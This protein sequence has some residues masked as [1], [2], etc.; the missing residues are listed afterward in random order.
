MSVDL[1]LVP[2]SEF[3]EW[4]DAE[5]NAFYNSSP[6]PESLNLGKAGYVFGAVEAVARNLEDDEPGSQF[7]LFQRMHSD[8]SIGWRPSELPALTQEFATISTALAAV[9]ISRS[10]LDAESDAEL[11]EWLATFRKY[12]PDRPLKS[13]YDFFFRF[14]QVFGEAMQRAVAT[15]KGLFVSY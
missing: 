13:V 5:W 8:D 3:L 9:P 7:P 10:A 14:F 2:G 11:E 15:D 12:S 1:Y 6:S 4:T